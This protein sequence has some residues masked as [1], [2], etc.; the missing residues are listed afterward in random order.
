MWCFT[1]A[2]SK[3]SNNQYGM[4]SVLCLLVTLHELQPQVRVYTSNGLSLSVAK[5]VNVL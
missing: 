2:T 4:D 5:P 1:V 3:F